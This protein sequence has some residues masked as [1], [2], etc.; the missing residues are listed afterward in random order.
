MSTFLDRLKR[1]LREIGP[2]SRRRDFRAQAPATVDLPDPIGAVRKKTE[3]DPAVSPGQAAVQRTAL[4]AQQPLLP[5]ASTQRKKATLAKAR[6]DSQSK[7][8]GEAIWGL[9]TAAAAAAAESSPL[10]GSPI[11][12]APAFLAGSSFGAGATPPRPARADQAQQP[13]LFDSSPAAASVHPWA[14]PSLAP[15]GGSPSDEQPF[16]QRSLELTGAP[17]FAPHADGGRMF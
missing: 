9:A 3:L 6:R 2:T 5:T 13:G 17:L 10:F 4:P 16:E 15:T 7:Q 12:N 1:S 14:S 11:N 8:A